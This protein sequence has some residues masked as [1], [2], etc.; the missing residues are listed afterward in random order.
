MY[1]CSYGPTI[2][3]QTSSQAE[4]KLT[5]LSFSIELKIFLNNTTTEITHEKVQERNRRDLVYLTTVAVSTAAR[6][7]PPPFFKGL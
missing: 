1:E 2:L 3:F 5:L 7:P 6:P 4:S